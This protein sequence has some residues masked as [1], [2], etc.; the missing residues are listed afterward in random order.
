M[1][2]VVRSLALL[3][4]VLVLVS[5][6]AS[7][8]AAERSWSER[9]A[10]PLVVRYVGDNQ[11]EFAWYA[12]AA[13]QAYRDVQDVFNSALQANNVAPRGRITISLYGDDDAYAEANPVAAREEGVLGHANPVAGEIGI[14]VAR[15]RERSEQTRR[16]SLR[17]ELTH[18]VLG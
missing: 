5:P 17:H 13:E 12:D 16:D 8:S 18:I 11:A 14:G 7:V 4:T 3:V 1:A 6:P 10:G 9:Q 2:L 15:L